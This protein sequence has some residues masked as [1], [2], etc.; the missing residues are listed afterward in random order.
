MNIGIDSCSTPADPVGREFV[1]TSDLDWAPDYV[2][3]DALELF[4]QCDVKVTLLATHSTKVLM[5][6]DE[7]KYELGIHPNFLGV[8]PDD[9]VEPRAVV[10]RLQELFPNA[11]CVRAHCLLESTTILDMYSEC[12][13]NYDL[14]QFIP[15]QSLPL[16]YRRPSGLVRVPF[17]W[18]DDYHFDSYRSFGESEVVLG[19]TGFDI[20]NFHPI[21]LFLNTETPDRYRDAKRRLE[22]DIEIH[23]IRNMGPIL[24]TRDLFL[25][26]CDTDSPYATYSSNCSLISL[27]ER[28]LRYSEDVPFLRATPLE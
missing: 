28:V 11:K 8:S 12:G 20:Y 18:E 13:L 19:P 25:K 21:H 9:N 27:V 16:P 24:G 23:S 5:G 7:G 4:E 15:Y 14:T 2:L 3:A 6:I 22:S 17:N 26:L 1:I 10:E